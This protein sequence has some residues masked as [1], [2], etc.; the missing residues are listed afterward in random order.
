ME[1]SGEALEAYLE[2]LMPE[3]DAVLRKLEEEA[4]QEGIP[5][6]GPH[7]GSLLMALSMA[8]RCEKAVELGT[9]IGYSAIWIARG[10]QPGG[11]LTTVEAREEMAKRA[12]E[13]IEDAGLGDEVEVVVG[14]AMEVLPTLGRDHDLIFNDIDKEEYPRV[15]PLCKDALRPGGLLVTDNVLWGGRVAS[16]DDK[17]PSTQA[18]RMYNR[19][20]AEDRDMVT[21][22]IPLR[23]GVSISV[24]R[25]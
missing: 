22:I 14:E 7:V 5:I 4:E 12:R 19:R 25:V 18:I 16:P 17:S 24:K 15:L 21:V 6:V 8:S 11:K 23:D 1:A 2:S 9:A 13:S 10:L 3:R 20:L